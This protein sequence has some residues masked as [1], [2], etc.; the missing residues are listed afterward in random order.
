MIIIICL[1]N[2]RTVLEQLEQ[3]EN[4]TQKK[5]AY[6]PSSLNNLHSVY[7]SELTI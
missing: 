3:F 4:R 2:S 1:H 6:L 5:R 7:L